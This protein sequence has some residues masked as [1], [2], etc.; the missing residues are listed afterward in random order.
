MEFV[1]ENYFV[2]NSSVGEL[3]FDLASLKRASSGLMKP[4]SSGAVLNF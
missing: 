2:L 1:L 4:T 3:G